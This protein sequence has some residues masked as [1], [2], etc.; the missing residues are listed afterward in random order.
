MDFTFNAHAYERNSCAVINPLP[1]KP[2]FSPPS[3]PHFIEAAAHALI[4]SFSHPKKK[5]KSTELRK[6]DPFL[7]SLPAISLRCK[8]HHIVFL[9]TVR[10]R[11]GRV[12][13][14]ISA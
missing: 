10:K 14:Y 9:E 1:S 3:A 12:E 11:L 4:H 2:H 5:E 8:P 6:G 7:R 13:E